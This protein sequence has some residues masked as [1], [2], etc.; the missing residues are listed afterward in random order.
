[1]EIGRVGNNEVM[2]CPHCDLLFSC[3]ARA[4]SVAI[5]ELN[6]VYRRHLL[7]APPCKAKDD[8]LPSL[9]ETLA[10][11]QPQY[12]EQEAKYQAGLESHPDNG[13]TGWWHVDGIRHAGYARASSAGEAVEKCATAGVVGEWESGTPAFVGEDLPEVFGC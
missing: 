9:R 7:E 5:D 1:M 2:A 4:D 12:Q 6:E 8:A 3:K 11:L 10:E 13:R